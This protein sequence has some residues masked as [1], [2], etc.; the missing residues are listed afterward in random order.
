MNNRIAYLRDWMLTK[1]TFGNLNHSELGYLMGMIVGDDNLIEY[2]LEHSGG[3]MIQSQKLL[4]SPN[5]ELLLQIT[6]KFSSR[7]NFRIENFPVRFWNRVKTISLEK[8]VITNSLRSFEFSQLV[9]ENNFEDIVVKGSVHFPQSDANTSIRPSDSVKFLEIRSSSSQLITDRYDFQGVLEFFPNLET[10]KV[11]NSLHF[12]P[13]EI[14]L[15][16]EFYGEFEVICQD[17]YVFEAKRK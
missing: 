4:K 6:K 13:T 14:L 12:I 1:K 7:N 8:P 10:I 17:I 11:Y 2:F 15:S 9:P 16:E 5:P 3:L